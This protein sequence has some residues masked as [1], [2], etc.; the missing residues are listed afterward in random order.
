MKLFVH[1]LG[2]IRGTPLPHRIIAHAVH[3]GHASVERQETDGKKKRKEPQS[4]HRLTRQPGC[5][6][7]GIL[8]GNLSSAQKQHAP[9]QRGSP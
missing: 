3:P 8:S 7:S 9:F 4:D 5:L 2:S 6:P 1:C